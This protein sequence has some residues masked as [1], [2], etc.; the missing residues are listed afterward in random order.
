[1]WI[2][3][4]EFNDKFGC[5]VLGFDVSL[6]LV[7]ELPLVFIQDPILDIVGL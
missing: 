1:M 4:L 5:E 2:S 3:L 7:N 6:D